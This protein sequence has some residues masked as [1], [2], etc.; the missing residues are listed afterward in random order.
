M[1]TEKLIRE[2]FAT[3]DVRGGL[4]LLEQLE[5]LLFARAFLADGDDGED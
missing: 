1:D 5:N 4:E 3:C 2:Y